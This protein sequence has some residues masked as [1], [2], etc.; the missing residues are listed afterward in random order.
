MHGLA[1]DGVRGAALAFERR[2][3]GELQ[4][5]K[6]HGGDIEKRSGLR[7]RA[8]ASGPMNDEGNVEGAL[9]TK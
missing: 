5:V 6:D 9:Y 8:A 1:I 7:L 2:R 3:D 4:I